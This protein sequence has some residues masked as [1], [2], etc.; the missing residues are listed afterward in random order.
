MKKIVIVAGDPNSVNSELIFKAWKK[1]DKSIKKKIYIIGN[2][3]LFKKQLNS[4]GHKK[5]IVK[6]NNI[7]D[8]INFNKLNIINID[9][10][11]KDPFNVS[12][13]SAS[14]FV[15][16]TLDFAHNLSKE[17][18][19]E[20]FINCPINKRILP[21]GN[22]V[23]EYLA[24]KCG[25]K[26]DSE[27]MLIKNEK[28]SVIPITTHIDIDQITKILN[29]KMIKDKINTFNN[30]FK[31]HHKRNPKIA[32]LGLNPHNAELKKNSQENKIV[33]PA[34]ISLKKNGINV[35]G[36]FVADTI[37]IQNYKNYDA[38]VGMY[39]DQVLAPFKALFKF[40]AINLTLGL[41]YLRASPDHG[42]A[43]DLIKKFK[44]NPTSL[45]RCIYFFNK[46][47]T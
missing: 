37:F 10:N 44:V 9:L 25:V 40:E 20:G 21:N 7:K 24:A 4:L 29:F 30:W 47:K 41:T 23:T 16:K 46:F 17:K 2:Y 39:H 18:L 19:I 3:D 32:I 33:K 12:K 13:K 8:I 26:K 31:K 27:V 45:L 36:P 42:V 28:L 35:S 38:I 11:F 43:L 6:L 5:K 34:I 15:K 1:L 14:N 22:G